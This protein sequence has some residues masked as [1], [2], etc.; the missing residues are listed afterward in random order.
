MKF[1]YVNIFVE[2]GGLKGIQNNSDSNLSES[3][4]YRNVIGEI[5]KFGELGGAEIRIT[6][7][8]K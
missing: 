8:D 7:R 1:N 6:A 5:E 3:N 4:V 2:L